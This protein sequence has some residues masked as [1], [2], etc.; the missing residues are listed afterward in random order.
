MFED[1]EYS[2]YEYHPYLTDVMI[3]LCQV[4]KFMLELLLP[5]IYARTLHHRNL[6][7]GAHH[8]RG[9]RFPRCIARGCA[10]HVGLWRSSKGAERDLKTQRGV[11]GVTLTLD[12]QSGDY[13]IVYFFFILASQLNSDLLNS[14]PDLFNDVY[15]VYHHCSC[16]IYCKFFP[17]CS[18]F[19]RYSIFFSL[20]SYAELSLST[21]GLAHINFLKMPLQLHNHD[22]LVVSN[23]FYV[24]PYLG[25]WSNLTDIFFKKNCWNHQL[26]NKIRSQKSWTSDYMYSQ[27]HVPRVRWCWWI[28]GLRHTNHTQLGNGGWHLLGFCD[29]IG[30]HCEGGPSVFMIWILLTQKRRRF[31]SRWLKYRKFNSERIVELS[32][33][34]LR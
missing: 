30:A 29:S 10:F 6:N 28:P 11:G 21:F 19:S 3:K 7:G 15:I 12:V 4:T 9:R 17:I 18:C 24:H 14:D 32:L 22:R 20:S 27:S 23:I 26:D 16:I 31:C 34:L 5:S 1:T 13:S 25:K 33:R 8:S 2:L